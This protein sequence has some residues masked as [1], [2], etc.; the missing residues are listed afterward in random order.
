MPL[1]SDRD[2]HA[3]ILVFLTAVARGHLRD[4]WTPTGPTTLARDYIQK[5]SPL[6]H[7]ER[8]MLRVAF[9][10]WNGQGN[11]SIADLIAGLDDD[12]LRLVLDLVMLARPGVR[13]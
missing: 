12:A 2:T 11:A 3:A 9:D 5:G 6:S 1:T 10:I 13:R 7:A 8:L 4:L